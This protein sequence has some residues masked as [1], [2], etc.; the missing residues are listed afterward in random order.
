[1]K[2]IT[3]L[4]TILTVIGLI[5]MPTSA[6]AVTLYVSTTD[7]YI[8]GAFYTG[9][10][11]SSTGSGV[12]DSFVRLSGGDIIEGYNTTVNNVFD[13]GATNQFNHEML[14]SEI[15]L[16]TLSDSIQYREFLLDNN[17]S[18]S[19]GGTEI[20]LDEIQIFQS[21][22]ANQS[23]ETFTSGI[24]DLTGSL[25]YQLDAGGDNT[26]II[27]SAVSSSGSGA[28]NMYLYVPNSVFIHSLDYIYL[29]SKFGT[30]IANNDGFEE[31]A[32]EIVSGD[33]IDPPPD[34]IPEPMTMLLFGS[35]LAGAFIQR[36]RLA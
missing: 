15:P 7:G 19:L 36:K 12:I 20:S 22:L 34:P 9:T 14:L 16:V 13:T 4:T 30:T 18:G 2:K 32:V 10:D 1:M 35:G 33:P 6:E 8:N 3:I 26:V 31:W 17:Q 21:G 23:V 25:V 27:D 5:G 11:E 24:V 28:A 29:Y